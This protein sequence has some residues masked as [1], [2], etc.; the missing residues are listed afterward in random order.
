[1]DGLRSDLNRNDT[2]MVD[3]RFRMTFD[4]DLSAIT[5]AVLDQI[6]SDRALVQAA[7]AQKGGVRADSLHGQLAGYRRRHATIGDQ[8]KS[9]EDELQRLFDSPAPGS[10]GAGFVLEQEIAGLKAERQTLQSHI[11]RLTSTAANAT[12][13][14]N[15][16]IHDANAELKSRRQRELMARRMAILDKLEQQGIG[17]DVAE[18]LEIAVHLAKIK[19]HGF[20]YVHAGP[21]SAPPV[22]KFLNATPETFDEA[23]AI[24]L[25]SA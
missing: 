2:V 22:E 19:P 4:A 9:K 5:Q 14:K 7:V 10:D 8:I 11:D 25:A 13:T 6:A 15:R 18:L 17:K 16:A 12:Y 1:M 20:A 24:V 23:A 3:G 21:V